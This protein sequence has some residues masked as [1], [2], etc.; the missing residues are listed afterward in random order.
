MSERIFEGSLKAVSGPDLLTFINLIKKTGTLTLL[1]GDRTQ[2]I[3]WEKGEMIFASSSDPEESLGAFLVRH[4]KITPEQNMKSGLL[5]EPGKRQGRILVQMGVLTPKSLWWAVK[6]Q[7]LEIIY[8]VFTIRDGRFHFEE[9]PDSYEEKIKLSTSTTNIIM[10]GIRRLDEWPRIKET[11]ANDRVVPR[12][13]SPDKRD[14]NVRFLEGEQAILAL[15]DGQ[16]TVRDI[17][18]HSEMEEFEILRLLMAFVMAR[19][20]LVPDGHGGDGRE[21]VEDSHA[22]ETIVE[23]Y[24]RI[25]SQMAG[26][27][28]LHMTPM[29]VADLLGRAWSST[30][31][32]VMEGISFDGEGRLDPRALT[33]NIA[34]VR[35]DERLKALEGGLNHLLSF[36]LFDASKHLAPE[37]KSALYKRVDE[38]SSNPPS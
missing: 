21:E 30:D 24:N 26:Y 14:Q 34:E 25:F 2:K 29:A 27:L 28:A 17:V 32:P 35:V 19:Y 38:L 18:H 20:V 16:R 15:V 3:Y 6:N 10:E 8:S 12:L 36:L 22:I 33:A 7:V 31:S 1:Q 23:S 37:E 4:G 5:V 9:T 13:G 11:I